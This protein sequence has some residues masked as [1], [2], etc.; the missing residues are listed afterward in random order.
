MPALPPKTSTLLPFKE[1]DLG[2]AARHSEQPVLVASHARVRAVFAMDGG[3]TRG[4]EEIL[5][6]NA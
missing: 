6:R 1:A 5:T 4:M 3:H 2:V